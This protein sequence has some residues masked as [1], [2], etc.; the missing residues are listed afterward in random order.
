MEKES[1][2]SLKSRIGTGVTYPIIINEKNGKSG[3]YPLEGS[4]E[5]IKE[6]IR[7]LILHPKGFRFRQ[8][9]YGTRIEEFIEEPD[10]QLVMTL[11]KL[12]IKNAIARYE[13]RVTLNK[14]TTRHIPGTI[15]CNLEYSINNTPI[16]DYLDIAYPLTI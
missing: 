10:T 5:S 14:I 16:Q 8:E 12:Y 4:P 9:D 3:W 2:T 11:I 6:N 15:T 7:A 13:P 1:L